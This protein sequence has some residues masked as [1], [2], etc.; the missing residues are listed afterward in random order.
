M[1]NIMPTGTGTHRLRKGRFSE[2]GQY[3]LLTTGIRG[4]KP[5]LAS[6]EAAKIVLSSLHWLEEKGRIQREAVVV[7]P[8]HLHFVAQL[9][10]GNLSQL[11]QVFK[12]YTAREINQTLQRKGPVWQSQYHDHAIRKDEVLE[13]IIL[14]CL[15]NPVRAGLVEDFH[16]YP[17]W[18]CHWPV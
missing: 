6:P 14:Y 11:M 18:Y 13:E 16:D 4:R 2:A 12:G 5:L 9:R 1:F 8:D 17:Y 10:L 15:R 7:M 3:Y